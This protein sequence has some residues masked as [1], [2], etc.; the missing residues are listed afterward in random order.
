VIITGWGPSN[1][2]NVNASASFYTSNLT[3][4][5][6][7]AL[8]GTYTVD[9]TLTP[10]PAS[11]A[12]TVTDAVTGLGVPGVTVTL[13]NGG[14]GTSAGTYG[15]PTN[16]AYTISVAT[17]G[18]QTITLTGSALTGYAYATPASGS[19]ITVAAGPNPNTNITLWPKGC[20]DGGSSGSFGSWSCSW[21]S[22]SNCP[23]TTNPD[24]SDGSLTCAFTQ[25]NAIRPGTYN[26]ITLPNNTCAWLDPRGGATGLA[27]GQMAGIYHVK[28]T[29][30]LGSNSY[31]FGDGVTIV[32]DQGS[33]FDV[34][35]GGGFVLNYGTIKVGGGLT[36]AH[37]SDFVTAKQFNDGLNP[38]FQTQTYDTQDYAYAAWTTNGSS[39]WQT[40]SG[41]GCVQASTPTYFTND[42]NLLDTTT[43]CFKPGTDLGITFYMYGSGLGN[44]SRMKLAT[45]NMGYL[46][47]GVLYAPKDDVQL[48]GGKDGQSAAGQIVG[49]TIEY[50]GG[51]RILQNWYGN[52]VDGQPF[53][54]EPVLG[55]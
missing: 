8:D 14:S 25:A 55:E 4:S 41:S 28:G 49:W 6:F 13:G 37:P 40:N 18:P 10:A 35:N 27:T 36:C 7:L 51:T 9:V 42:T 17:P 24:A 22:G 46:F 32:M 34:N 1:T 11:V 16:G 48:G 39:P 20:Y 45:A 44:N 52:P 26:D 21:P 33:N 19:T 23:A 2:W 38:C 53:L 12:G 15:T 30:S 50:H 29:I 5:G 31:L 54:I 47:N 3:N 43:T